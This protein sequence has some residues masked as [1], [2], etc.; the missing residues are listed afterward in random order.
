MHPELHDDGTKLTSNHELE[1]G[2]TAQVDDHS[3]SEEMEQ[4]DS[5]V[6]QCI[7]ADTVSPLEIDAE[8]RAPPRTYFQS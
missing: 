1:S 4:M 5:D 2:R 3:E 7:Q 6:L 8:L